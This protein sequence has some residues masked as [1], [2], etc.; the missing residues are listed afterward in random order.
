MSRPEQFRPVKKGILA[1]WHDCAPGREAEFETWYQ[2]EHLFE[3]LAVP[4]FLFG[5]RLEALSG[6]PRYFTYY[7]TE[8]VGTLTSP[9]YLE[10]LDDP[11]PATKT[12][13]T[14]VFRNMSRTVCRREKR[15]GRLRGALLVTARFREFPV[16]PDTETWMTEYLQDPGVANV[17]LWR[18]SEP[19][20]MPVAEEERLR[21]GDQKI[22][23]CL[24]V[25]TLQLGAART[26]VS[27]LALEFPDAETGVYQTLCQIGNGES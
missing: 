2:Q 15:V 14:E 12:M 5:R 19:D 24:V 25:E 4:G 7:V 20:D 21:C 26:I 18:G 16:L 23:G 1:V 9:D 10:R 6:T 13:M 11:T 17:E 8:A 22:D 3:R 27:D